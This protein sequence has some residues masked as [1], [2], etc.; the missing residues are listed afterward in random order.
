MAL[1]ASRDDLEVLVASVTK[2]MMEAG[3]EKR[4]VGMEIEVAVG[5]WQLAHGPELRNWRRRADRLSGG[6]AVTGL[7]CF[8]HFVLDI[9]LARMLEG[10]KIQ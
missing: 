3:E 9:L 1:E 4:S 10:W 7:F 2:R 8:L 5:S 6:F